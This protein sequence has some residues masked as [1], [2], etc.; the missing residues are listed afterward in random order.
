MIGKKC[1]HSYEKLDF[2]K[3]DIRECNGLTPESAQITIKEYYNNRFIAG[4]LKNFIRKYNCYGDI[5]PNTTPIR[6]SKANLLQK[7]HLNSPLRLT[8]RTGEGSTG[9]KPV[10][11]EQSPIKESPIPLHSSPFLMTPISK[12]LYAGDSPYIGPSE[13]MLKKYFKT[14]KA[15]KHSE[16]YRFR[17]DSE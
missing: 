6:A 15:I 4:H 12:Q 17:Q 9:L 1:S 3:R 5:N 11:K 8:L 13:P 16:T 10:P 14:Y 2:I 7:M